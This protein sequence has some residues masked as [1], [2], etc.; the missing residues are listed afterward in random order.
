MGIEVWRPY[1]DDNV[2]LRRKASSI[3]A[4]AD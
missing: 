4:L 2:Y 3:W 1:D